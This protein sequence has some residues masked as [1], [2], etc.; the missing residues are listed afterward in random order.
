M[1]LVCFQ[2]FRITDSMEIPFQ[3]RSGHQNVLKKGKMK[4]VELGRSVGA[5]WVALSKVI[6]LEIQSLGV[7]SFHK[8]TALAM[9]Q[10]KN[11]FLT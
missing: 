4:L 7:S 5:C 11:E 8:T 2:Q 9:A 3:Q 6:V 10:R 1:T